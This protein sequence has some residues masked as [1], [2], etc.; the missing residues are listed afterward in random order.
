MGRLCRSTPVG[1]VANYHQEAERITEM[2]V[3]ATDH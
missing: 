3:K 2:L 1:K